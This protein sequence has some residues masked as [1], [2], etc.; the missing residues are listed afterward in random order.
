MTCIAGLAE[1]G[2]VWMAGDSAGISGWD[3]TVRA[4][5]KVFV[6]GPYV[7][8]YAGSFRGGQLLNYAFSPPVPDDGDLH[9]FMCTAFT[10]ALRACLKDGG[11]AS[12]DQ[13]QEEGG[14]FLAGVHGRL[15]RI[16]TDYGVGE[17]ADGFLAVG[18]GSEAARGALF[19]LADSGLDPVQ[20]LGKAL[21]A[22]ERMSAGV[23][24]PATIARTPATG[25][26]DG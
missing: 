23:R 22:A 2:T 26:S 18:C 25:G 20:R 7:I 9:G 5:P 3:L 11:Y 8:G 10:D 1:G 24:G 21:A 14:T 19:A 4:D 16:D 12:T 6:N 17:S 15:F 13:D